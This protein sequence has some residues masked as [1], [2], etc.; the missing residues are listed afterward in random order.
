MYWHT[1]AQRLR[2]AAKVIQ[3]EIEAGLDHIEASRYE[4]GST[5]AAEQIPG[6][7]LWPAFGLLAAFALENLLKGILVWRRPELV[8]ETRLDRSLTTH[9][10]VPLA[11]RAGFTLDPFDAYFLE[12]AT[13]YS[14]WAGKY[15]TPKE[16][17]GPTFT[18]A[19]SDANFVAFDR[20]YSNFEAELSKAGRPRVV[21]K[22]IG[23]PPRRCE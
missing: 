5:I 12:A 10:L 18:L 7:Q 21:Y 17:P 14:T 23:R 8:L 19:S 20:L 1:T 22:V 2:A 6:L 15:H 3:R 16:S 13:E 4:D 11:R 9:K